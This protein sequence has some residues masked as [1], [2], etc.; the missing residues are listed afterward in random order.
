MQEKIPIQRLESY[1]AI[2]RRTAEQISAFAQD[3]RDEYDD[4]P[5]D[6]TETLRGAYSAISD[7]ATDLD[8][9]MEGT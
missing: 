2:L 9:W 3:W 1:I 4:L 6:S 8:E 5:E 7:I